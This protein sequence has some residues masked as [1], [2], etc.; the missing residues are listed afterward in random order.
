MAGN[1]SEGTPCLPSPR[2]L[3]RLAKSPSAGFRGLCSPGSTDL[4]AFTMSLDVFE[5]QFAHLEMGE[6][7]SQPYL[8]TSVVVCKAV[9][10]R[11]G[12]DQS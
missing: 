12:A 10:M 4:M 1:S 5:D 9:R 8:L 2:S 6:M 11:A 7:V 3:K